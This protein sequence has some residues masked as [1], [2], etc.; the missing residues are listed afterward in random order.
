MPMKWTPEADQMLLLKI[1]ETSNVNINPAKISETWPS[2]M[3]GDKPTKRAIQ[4]RLV[5][6]REKAKKD[7]AAHFS[8]TSGSATTTNTTPRAPRTPRKPNGAGKANTNTSNS[9]G[10]TPST[11]PKRTPRSKALPL[12]I[13][14]D[15]DT[16]PTITKKEV[17]NLTTDI[18]TLYATT[19]FKTSKET[20]TQSTP[21][22]G[23][24]RART[25]STSD[26][27][28]EGE[29]F[30]DGDGNAFG[31]ETPSKTKVGKK[32]R[33]SAVKVEKYESDGEGDMSDFSE[34]GLGADVIV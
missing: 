14:D 7:G 9:N 3:G 31:L 20:S 33:V 30:G 23:S 10:T 19:P 26:D 8:I 34:W 16:S 17:D 6:I 12:D 21:S 5:K 13:S 24:K 1:L 11:R 32:M 22:T 18:E 15:S 28:G 2:T 29:D 4:E 27:D 25:P